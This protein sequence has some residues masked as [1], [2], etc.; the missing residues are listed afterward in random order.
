MLRPIGLDL[1]RSNRHRHHIMKAFVVAAA[2]ANAN[3]QWTDERDARIAS[4]T[5]T[6]VEVI[7]AHGLAGDRVEWVDVRVAQRS[8]FMRQ[9]FIKLRRPLHQPSE[10][11]LWTQDAHASDNETTLHTVL[12]PATVSGCGGIR[13]NSMELRSRPSTADSV[14][15]TVPPSTPI[16]PH[17]PIRMK[18]GSLHLAWYI[19]LIISCSRMPTDG[20]PIPWLTHNTGPTYADGH[21]QQKFPIYTQTYSWFGGLNV[22]ANTISGFICAATK[23][24]RTDWP[25]M[26]ISL[27][28]TYLIHRIAIRECT[29]IGQLGA[30]W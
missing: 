2:I 23:I 26:R 24:A 6:F 20:A 13:T 10:D 22:R 29:D 15:T 14:I 21:E 5:V 1:S 9:L 25:K 27:N 28:A 7:S 8:Q 17:V 3:R 12:W 11:L 16:P 30:G 4:K 18:T 19:N